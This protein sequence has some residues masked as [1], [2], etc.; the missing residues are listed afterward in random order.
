MLD[1]LLTGTDDVNFRY[2]NYYAFPFAK[3]SPFL[4]PLKETFDKMRRFGVLDHI[5]NRYHSPKQ[6]IKCEDPKVL[7][8]CCFSI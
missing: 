8:D 4:K 2:V 1:Y 7:L 5:W 3:E 6:G